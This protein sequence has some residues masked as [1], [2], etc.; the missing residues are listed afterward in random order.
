M[1]NQILAGAVIQAGQVIAGVDANNPPYVGPPV[2]K[3]ITR[4]V[5][6]M[7][8]TLYIRS[9]MDID[10]D[11]TTLINTASGF[12][13]DDSAVTDPNGR[14]LA[15]ADTYEGGDGVVFV[16]DTQDLSVPLA[17]LS[18]DSGEATYNENYKFGRSMAMSEDK[19]FIGNNAQGVPVYCY[20]LSDLSASP[21]KISTPTSYHNGD[22]RFS[23]DMAANSTHL[24]IGHPSSRDPIN[25]NDNQ[26]EGGAVHV[27][28]VETL[29]YQTS[30]FGENTEY[31]DQFGFVVDATE[32]HLAVGAYGDDEHSGTQ[33]Q[34]G[35]AYVF[36]LSDLTAAPTK[37][38][39]STYN[40]EYGRYLSLSD[41]HLAVAEPNNDDIIGMNAANGAV[42][43][44]SL[45]DL[46]AAPIVQYGQYYGESLGRDIHLFNDGSNR[47]S[48]Y[49]NF[50]NS[51]TG[52][53]EKWFVYNISDMSTPLW[54]SSTES[55]YLEL[56]AYVAPLPPAP[57]SYFMVAAP[58]DDG[59]G[60]GAGEVY[61]Y[62]TI[63][64]DDNSPD[65]TIPSP[66]GYRAYFGHQMA[67]NSTHI[68]IAAYGENTYKGAVY[69][70][71]KSDLT[72]T[73]QRIEPSGLST[74]DFIAAY[75][76]A[77]SD[78]HLVFGNFGDD[79]RGSNAGS[80]FIYNLDT[81]QYTELFPP[82]SGSNIQFGFSCAL[83]DTHVVIT[84]AGNPAHNG[85]LAQNAYAW[86]LS[87]GNSYSSTP[88]VRF[89]PDQYQPINGHTIALSGGQGGIAMSGNKVFI[90]DTGYD[91][92]ADPVTGY[93]ND[94]TGAVYMLDMENPNAD[95]V[96]FTDPSPRDNP[97]Q[98]QTR[99]LGHS[100]RV[101]GNKLY[102][103]APS[104]GE[105]NSGL[106][107]V[108]DIEDPSTVTKI[109][110]SNAYYG[111]PNPAFGERISVQGASLLVGAPTYVESGSSIETGAAYLYNLNDL[112]QTGFLITNTTS[113]DVD[114]MGMGVLAVE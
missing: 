40:R 44:Y 68:A 56:P 110:P 47:I 10:A 27:Y 75:S 50:G 34:T 98:D 26:T 63:E 93:N 25:S 12:G 78:T 19:L 52:Q 37:L 13:V 51:G 82:G 53:G 90:G 114:R 89:N 67:Q 48:Y 11:P 65:L 81:M 80:A 70:Y 57:A 36:N 30:L 74:Y 108:W 7:P 100:V 113:N 41:T 61:V 20:D 5:T 112:S 32:T 14:Y 71:D 85:G 99:Q 83:S 97:S 22:F 33:V 55:P 35:A 21:I 42:Y 109:A 38:E 23:Y 104:G 92:P 2:A 4:S 88:P 17:T 31:G 87:S 3:W 15:V 106:V 6:G 107:L 43:V 1:A 24:F 45:G 72:A 84:A 49:R 54:E 111:Q 64:G 76:L 91:A 8:R 58:Y 101:S 96:V 94:N 77:M 39:P 29:Q 28:D 102:A 73:P 16:Y 18:P 60:D 79:S 59:G 103:G 95:P 105:H 46:S 69:L 66:S 9:V 62:N 86:P